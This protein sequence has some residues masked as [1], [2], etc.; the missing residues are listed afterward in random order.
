MKRIKVFAVLC[1]IIL[2]CFSGNVSAENPKVIVTDEAPTA[3]G[4]YSQGIESNGFLFT[5]GQIPLD[6]ITGQLVEGGIAEQTAQ[7]MDNLGAILAETGRDFCDVVMVTV[8]MKN[9]SDF[10]AFNDVYG[11]YFP[12]Y[13]PARA[14]FEAAALPKGAL[15]EIWMIAGPPRGKK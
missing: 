1:T 7:V 6:P 8:V 15:V 10:S 13:A 5:A 9:L 4:P 12:G 3:I 14:T 11:S 2:F